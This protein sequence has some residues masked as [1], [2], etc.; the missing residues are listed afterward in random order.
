MNEDG[1][2]QERADL[3]RLEQIHTVW[4][5]LSA[6][7]TKIREDLVEKLVVR[8]D[9]EVRG[10]IKQIDELLDLPNSIIRA[11]TQLRGLAE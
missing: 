1:L 3:A 8:E 6:H 4:P 2:S 5:T 7:L 10:R 11:Q 9:N